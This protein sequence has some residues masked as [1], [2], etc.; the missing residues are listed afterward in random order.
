MGMGGMF[1]GKGDLNGILESGEPLQV[2]EV[3][4]KAVIEIDEKGTEA[5]AATGF[6]IMAI[7][8]P[9]QFDVNHPFMYFI[10]DTETNTIIF[11]GRIEKF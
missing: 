6:G 7:S 3:I 5:S 1:S 2:S 4:H 11:S 9:P 8:L 10:R